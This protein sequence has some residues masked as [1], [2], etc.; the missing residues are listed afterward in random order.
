MPF[1]TRP[2]QPKPLGATVNA[3]GVNFSLFSENAT[4]VAL[5]L[6]NRSDDLQPAQVIEI[7]QPTQFYW[8]V[9]VDGLVANAAYAYRV[10]GPSGDMDTQRFGYRFN[11]NKV[12]IDP[13]SHGNLD[14]LW[15]AANAEDDSDNVAT[16]MRSFVIDAS[17]YDREGD[18]P[19]NVPMS[20]TVIYELHVRGYTR[21]GSSGV[22]HPGTFSGL[23]EKLPYIKSLGVTAI[24]LM[25]VFDF[26][27]KTPKRIGPVTGLPLVN[28][29]GYDPI[30]F[31]APQLHYCVSPDAATHV[32]EFRDLIKA[33]HRHG[34]EVIL[35]VV[36]KSYRG[37]GPEWAGHRFQGN[38][39]QGVLFSPNQ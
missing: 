21:S 9:Q 32:T 34:L 39:Q 31:F 36:F 24:E 7:D 11:G 16:S 35:D 1:T 18:T 13:Y 6:F 14:T 15:V 37:G 2:G 23:I 26:D 33:A 38:R 28:F 29:W 3:A 19:P 12:L 20:D 25:P 10:F 17:N 5:L 4:K 8:H 27:A 22:A 30:T